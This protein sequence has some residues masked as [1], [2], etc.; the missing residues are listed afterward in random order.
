[1]RP[2]RTPASRTTISS[3]RAARYRPGRELGVLGGA[4]NALSFARSVA[5]PLDVQ[6]AAIFGVGRRL[7]GVPIRPWLFKGLHRRVEAVRLVIRNDSPDGLTKHLDPDT[8]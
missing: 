4:T 1:M 6:V 8:R 2:P 3:T 7:A 5:A